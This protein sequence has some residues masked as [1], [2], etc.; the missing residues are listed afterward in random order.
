MIIHIPEVLTPDE[1]RHVRARLDAEGDWTDGRE[2]VGY[3]GA[4]VKRNEQLADDSPLKAELGRLLLQALHRHPLFFAAALPKKI[5]PPRFNRYQGGGTYGFHV[6]GSVMTARDGLRLRTDVSC[7]LFLS[8]PDEYD[9]GHLRIRD[10]YGDH[11]VRHPAGDAV[12]YPSTSFHQVD[13]VTKGARIASFFWIESLVRESEKR[14]TLFEMDTA[15][16]KL[17][18]DGA[19]DTAILQLTGVYH[20]LMR[21]WADT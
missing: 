15:I 18:Q 10:T 6:D 12:L 9:G 5:L 7:T 1:V 11:A 14:R 16:Q 3:Q 20:N 21:R 4:A 2:T 8:D 19:D 17:R 13:P